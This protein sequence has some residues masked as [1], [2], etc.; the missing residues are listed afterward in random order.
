MTFICRHWAALASSVFTLRKCTAG[1]HCKEML[2]LSGCNWKPAGR[3][4]R[5]LT[6]IA[7]IAKASIEL[8]KCY[9][10][11]IDVSLLKIEMH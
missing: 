3:I 6:W 9:E 4:L 2:S 7:K 5:L 10:K 11:D 8:L 1:E